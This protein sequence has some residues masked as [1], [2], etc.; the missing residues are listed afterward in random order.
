MVLAPHLPADAEALQM[1]VGIRTGAFGSVEIHTVVDQSQ[2]GI[3]IHGDRELARWFNAEVGGLTAGLKNQHLNL[4]A[5]DFNSGRSSM[6]TATNFQ[7]GQP[8]Q[9][10]SQSSGSSAAALPREQ[11]AREPETVV[12]A[13][14]AIEAR[15]TRVSILA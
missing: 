11:A 13:S 10:F 6:Q 2:V 7:Q 14:L 1:H 15:E 12:P 9:S 5:V 4:T 3:A 8:R